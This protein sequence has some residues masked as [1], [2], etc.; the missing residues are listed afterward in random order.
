MSLSRWRVQIPPTPETQREGPRTG[1]AYHLV[2]KLGAAE[3]SPGD[4]GMGLYHEWDGTHT[5]FK[6]VDVDAKSW[7]AAVNLAMD[8]VYAEAK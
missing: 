7:Q 8:I 4:V 2:N 6:E 3:G 5:P 1:L